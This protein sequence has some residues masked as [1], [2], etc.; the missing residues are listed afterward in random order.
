[1]LILFPICSSKWEYIE[2]LIKKELFVIEKKEVDL[3]DSMKFNLIYDLYQGEDWLGDIS[4]N[5]EG[6]YY[7]MNSCFK[8]ETKT[9]KFFYVFSNDK[10]IKKIKEEIRNICQCGKHSIH[11]TDYEKE[12]NKLKI[13]Y[14]RCK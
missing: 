2:K 1:M 10:E 4:N 9:V 6:I 13:K 14:L 11:S 8:E 12:A 3:S 5:W 7:K